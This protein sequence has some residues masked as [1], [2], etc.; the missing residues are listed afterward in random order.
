[1]NI[2][3]TFDGIVVSSEYFRFE[4]IM[5]QPTKVVVETNRLLSSSQDVRLFFKTNVTVSSV[6]I[7][8]SKNNFN[9]LLSIWITYKY[10]WQTKHKYTTPQTTELNSK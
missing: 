4:D 3:M 1:M 2:E 9:A 7:D 8:L 6:S 5:L 10:L